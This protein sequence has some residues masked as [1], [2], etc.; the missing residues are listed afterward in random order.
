MEAVRL[1]VVIPA[2]NEEHCIGEAVDSALSGKPLE[3]IAVDGGSSDRTADLA[4]T[5]G[6]TVV[7]SPPGRGVQLHRG[8]LAASGDLLLFL[9]ADCR[10]PRDYARHVQAILNGRKVVAGAF[11]L[12]IDAPH[13]SL[14]AI[15]KLVGLRSRFFRMPYGDQAIFMRSDIYHRVGGFPLTEAMED[16]ELMRSLRRVGRIRIARAVVVASGRR[17]TSRGIWSTTLLN[18]ACVGA[19]LLGVSPTRIATWR[20]GRTDPRAFQRRKPGPARA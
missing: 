6:A 12:G 5:H 17:W 15:E 8:A 18:Q 19:Y 3:V 20:R 4:R 13:R 16:F 11:R 9:H 7:T 10:L 1:S 2:L 14:R